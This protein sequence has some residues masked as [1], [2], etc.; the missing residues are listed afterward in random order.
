MAQASTGQTLPDAALVPVDAFRFGSGDGCSRTVT[1]W[2]ARCRPAETCWA[3]AQLAQVGLDLSRHLV[4]AMPGPM[5]AVGQ[6][7]QA[8]GGVAAQ[9][10]VDGL[11]AHTVAVGHL[12]HREPVAQHL[13][14]GVE[15][16]SATV[17]S[18]STL[19]TSSP[20]RWSAKQQKVRR[21]CQPSTGTL[22]PI[23][24]VCV[25]RRQRRPGRRTPVGLGGAALLSS[26][27]GRP[28]TR[29]WRHNLAK[30]PQPAR[31]ACLISG[32]GRGL[33]WTRILDPPCARSRE[34]GHERC[35]E[36]PPVVGDV[37][38][39][40]DNRRHSATSWTQ[41]RLGRPLPIRRPC[42]GA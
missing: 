36:W 18:G 16:M 39:P 9:P 15:A 26:H 38:D 12:D 22:E 11:A 35:R 1:T 3:S 8:A 19:P 37:R 23:S 34:E 32:A 20:R 21:W 10:A 30:P 7:V 24:R 31:A 13:H 2:P 6:G 40:D 29:P 17:S 5:R 33:H 41:V 42:P 14:D 27:A 25:G 28:T 4:G